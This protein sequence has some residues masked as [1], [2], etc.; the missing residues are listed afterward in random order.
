MKQHKTYFQLINYLSEAQFKVEYVSM[1]GNKGSSTVEAE[2][3]TN[4]IRIVREKDLFPTSIEEIKGSPL[5]EPVDDSTPMKRLQ[6]NKEKISLGS[7]I[8]NAFSKKFNRMKKDIVVGLA[9]RYG[10][11]AGTEAA[12]RWIGTSGERAAIKKITS[13][14]EAL[15]KKIAEL[16]SKLSDP[17]IN[18]DQKENINQQINQL[19]DKLEQ[20]RIKREGVPEK[21]IRGLEKKAADKSERISRKERAYETGV[22]DQISAA[23]LRNF[24]KKNKPKS[25]IKSPT[26]KSGGAPT[27]ESEES[28]AP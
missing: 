17:T 9:A 12:K 28:S 8:K 2:D 7:I 25:K 10:G 22:D 23:A 15:K 14:E 19:E 1:D 27:E 21:G 18:D 20:L 13:Q 16:D 4:A 3:I 11:D 5:E 26:P 24:L 6:T